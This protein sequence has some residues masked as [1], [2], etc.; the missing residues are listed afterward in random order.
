MQQ[1]TIPNS[2][3]SIGESAFN[4]CS[5]LEQVT[6][7]DSVTS[8]ENRIFADCTSLEQI[9]VS[10]NSYDKIKRMLPEYLQDIVTI[11]V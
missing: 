6:I 11:N 10:S 7:P 9:L 5:S 8:I 3:T 4:G 2:V 1:I